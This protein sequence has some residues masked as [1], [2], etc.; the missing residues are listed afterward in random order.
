MTN[1]TPKRADT[2]KGHLVDLPVALTIAGSD[3][4]GG[5]GIQADLKTF[6][7]MGCFGTSAITAITAQNTTGVRSI[8]GI[9]PQVVRDQIE[10]VVE[11]LSPKAAKTGMIATPQ[12]I[13]VV[14]EAVKRYELRVVVDPVMVAA[15]GAKLVQDD[16]V[17]ALKSRLIPLAR[18]LTPNRMEAETLTG[19][20]ITDQESAERA[21]RMLL[22]LGPRA[23]LVKGGHIE[24]ESAVDLLVTN[25]GTMRFEKP[26]IDTDATHGT[27]CTLAAA[28]AAGIAQDKELESA[29]REAEALIEHG[30]RYGYAMGSGSPAVHHSARLRNDAARWRVLTELR[31]AR[32][33]LLA[34]PGASRLCAEVGMNLA[35]CTPYAVDAL[36]VAATEG[37]ITRATTPTGRR[38]VANGAVD[39]GASKHMARLLLTLRHYDPQVGA[40]MNVRYTQ[41]IVDALHELDWDVVEADRANEPVDNK[42]GGSSMDWAARFAMQ[43]RQQAPDAITDPGEPGKEAMVRLIGSGAGEVV[44]RF[45]L[46]ADRVNKSAV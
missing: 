31:V 22:E 41:E 9:D 30:L 3:S 6:E 42:A 36:D 21:G 37:R 23:V 38:L 1:I 28:I 7:A 32:E 17:E 10:A 29:V 45:A 40:V 46:L 19:S 44:E 39:F 43:D 24:G 14:A 8:Q 2:I 27:G 20:K 5:A 26:R 11:D 4:G 16:A 18:V 33:Q 34:T 13:E 15:S 12:L 25:K 35:A